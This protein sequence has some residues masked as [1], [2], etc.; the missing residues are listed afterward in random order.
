M[1]AA[2][3][4]SESSRRNQ[5]LKPRWFHILLALSDKDLHGSDIMREVLEQSGGD[6]RLWPAMLYSS[7]EQMVDQGLIEELKNPAQR[8]D[9]ASAKLR[10]FRITNDGRHRL[11][12]EAD[13]MA[14][15]AQL[16]RA[17]NLLRGD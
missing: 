17:K 2:R 3:R 5:A 15:M 14:A 9:G 13:R 16:A 4:S 1:A 8:P 10:Y 7:L 12:S 11:G 6:L